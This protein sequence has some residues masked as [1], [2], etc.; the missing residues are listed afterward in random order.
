[1]VKKSE[2]QVAQLISKRIDELGLLQKDVARACG[3]PKPNVI[4]MLKQGLMKLPLEKVGPLAKVL[5]LH[6]A[7]LF[8]MVLKEYAPETLKSIDTPTTGIVAFPHEQRIVA[9]YRQLVGGPDIAKEVTIS[10]GE[11]SITVKADD[12]LSF[13]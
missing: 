2:S 12:A 3:W 8:W 7:L 9:A 11:R 4:T 1:M 5:G 13:R 6:P 10:D